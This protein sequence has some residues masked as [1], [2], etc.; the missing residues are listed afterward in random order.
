MVG[1][2]SRRDEAEAAA[3]SLGA[4]Y[5]YKPWILTVEQAEEAPAV[6]EDTL[7]GADS[8]AEPGGENPG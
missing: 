6:P 5:G 1:P 4:R 2:Y 8:A 3:R 7:G